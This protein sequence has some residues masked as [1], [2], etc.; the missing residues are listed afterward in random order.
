M[1]AESKAS[2]I[3]SMIPVTERLA[4]RNS[5]AVFTV[6]AGL[7]ALRS[8]RGGK[9]KPKEAAEAK[10]GDDAWGEMVRTTL[11]AGL[12][13]EVFGRGQTFTGPVLAGVLSVLPLR[14]L[15]ND[16]SFHF[17]YKFLVA[18]LSAQV[19]VSWIPQGRTRTIVVMLLSASQLLGWWVLSDTKLPDDYL[20]FLDREGKVDRG[21]HRDGA[22]NLIAKDNQLMRTRE[23]FLNKD[24]E[25]TWKEFKHIVFPRPGGIS[26]AEQYE[27]HKSIW[28][29]QKAGLHYLGL[30]FKESVPFYLKIYGLRLIAG[31]LRGG[32]VGKVRSHGEAGLAERIAMTLAGD[33]KVAQV[34]GNIANGLLDVCR[35]A[36]FLSLYCTIPWWAIGMNGYIFPDGKTSPYDPRIWISL[37]LPGLAILVESPSQQVTISNYCA[38]FGVYPLLSS[39]P[40]MLDV[41][42]ALVGFACTSGLA[43]RP[44]LL[45]L[46]WPAD[47]AGVRLRSKQAQVA[48]AAAAAIKGVQVK[49]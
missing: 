11:A 14:L 27:S 34:S 30:H 43:E 44:F 22:L 1:G 38:T 6:F 15:C 9:K 33:P 19:L 28:N 36:G 4:L 49:E 25:R 2:P 18:Y 42:A 39:F 37:A 46:L 48:A 41:S 20:R 40:V 47:R 17:N 8:L 7:K 21:G 35:S 3:A 16:R 26:L 32:K 45:N 31:L 29:F 5:I 12:T 23:V 10:K 24:G 13:A